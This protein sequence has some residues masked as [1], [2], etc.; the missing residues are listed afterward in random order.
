MEK[1]ILYIV[2][3]PIGNLQDMTPRAVEV[4]KQVQRIA[5][6]DTRRS[7]ILLQQFA[8]KTPM[9][10]L[11]EHNERVA[12]EQLVKQLLAGESIALISD[13]GTPLISDP[14]YH[15]VRAAQDAD[16]KVVPVPGASALLTALSAAGLPT[17]RFIFE[18][19]MP[20]KAGPRQRR[21][22]AMAQETCTL[23]YYE[24][25]HRI[26]D[27]LQA[28]VLAFG[29]EREAVIARELTKTFETI[30]RD[31][32]AELWQWVES[33][34]NQQKGEIVILVHGAEEEAEQYLSN[35]DNRIIELLAS[36]LPLKKAA[37]LAAKITGKKKNVLYQIGRAHV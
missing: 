27:T 19:F 22:E 29:P 6:E 31:S 33:D 24:A 5:A 7:G 2:A 1:G 3:T 35:E 9:M 37:A 4:L 15:L 18:G 13:A 17:D 36:E 23:V 12:C 14:G 21:L 30:H 11:H 28:M 34:A 26:T 8:I 32:L 25:P 16:C 20:A 10:A